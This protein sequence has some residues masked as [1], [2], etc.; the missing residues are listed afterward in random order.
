MQ[1][2]SRY[3]PKHSLPAVAWLRN[4]HEVNDSIRVISFNLSIVNVN[5]NDGVKWAPVFNASGTH[6]ADVRLESLLRN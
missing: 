1:Q 3:R 6:M 5:V 2:M 4:L